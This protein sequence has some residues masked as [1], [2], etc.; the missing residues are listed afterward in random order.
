M[1]AQLF[2]IVD[3]AAVI[4]R[5]K[6]VYRQAKVY[7]RMGELYAGWGSG[8]IGLRR[9]KGTTLP[10]VS[11]ETLDAPGVVTTRRDGRLAIKQD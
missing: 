6:G 5:A 3:D 11:W 8:F 7:V 10:N 4:L 1:T 9:E 2:H